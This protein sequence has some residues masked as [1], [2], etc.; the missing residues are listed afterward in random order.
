MISKTKFAEAAA[1]L[2]LPTLNEAGKRRV[3]NFTYKMEAAEIDGKP[4]VIYHANELGGNRYTPY[5]TDLSFEYEWYQFLSEESE[6]DT[7]DIDASIFP[8]VMNLKNKYMPV[9]VQDAEV[10]QADQTVGYLKTLLWN[11]EYRRVPQNSPDYATISKLYIHKEKVWRSVD[12]DIKPYTLPSVLDYIISEARTKLIQAQEENINKNIVLAQRKVARPLTNLEEQRICL[13]TK[14][15]MIPAILESITF[16]KH[17]QNQKTEFDKTNWAGEEFKISINPYATLPETKEEAKN[18]LFKEL[19]PQIEKVNTL[20]SIKSKED[21][22]KAY[23][24]LMSVPEELRG[25]NIIIQECEKHTEPM[26]RPPWIPEDK[27]F[28]LTREWGHDFTR[29]NFYQYCQENGVV[30]SDTTIT[31]DLSDSDVI[32]QGF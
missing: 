18:I 13:L 11:N 16:G 12:K 5:Q 27:E 19:E 28:D 32:G 25:S 31:D 7:D 29:E 22:D 4:V 1:R 14:K 21:C 6:I 30:F 10:E 9:E 17:F 8:V 2:F 23:D 20:L 24:K 26:E 15:Y 3:I